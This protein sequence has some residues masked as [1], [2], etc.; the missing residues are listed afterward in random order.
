MIIQI[1][2][3]CAKLQIKEYK[4]Q[5][6][7]FVLVY[8][9]RLAEFDPKVV[10]I[11]TGENIPF[12]D[13]NSEITHKPEQTMM[14]GRVLHDTSAM[15]VA[16]RGLVRFLLDQGEKFY[17]NQKK[18]EMDGF[19]SIFR[20]EPDNTKLILDDDV[21][22]IL[23]LSGITSYNMSHVYN[24]YVGCIVQGQLR[25]RQDKQL[26]SLPDSLVN[27]STDKLA[28]WC[29]TGVQGAVGARV[30]DPVYISSVVI[31]AANEQDVQGVKLQNFLNRTLSDK[32]LK[33]SGYLPGCYICFRYD[34]SYDSSSYDSLFILDQMSRPCC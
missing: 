29:A 10:S 24:P 14:S 8:R 22:I 19:D 11:G 16:R 2:Q 33:Q 34:S 9:G 1:E 5:F 25:E 3:I 31:G 6:A 7:A 4:S 17:K 26:D 15:V 23:Y 12:I 27:Y 18:M 32:M 13:S 28:K 30:M 21:E 20:M